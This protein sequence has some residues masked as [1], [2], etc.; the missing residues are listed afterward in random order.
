M[1][2]PVQE[3]LGEIMTTVQLFNQ[4]SLAKDLGFTTDGYCHAMCL[5]WIRRI[6]QNRGR[7]R[8]MRFDFDDADTKRRTVRRQMAIQDAL[9]KKKVDLIARIPVLQARAK[10]LDQSSIDRKSLANFIV[11][12]INENPDLDSLP[13]AA[14]F[15]PGKLRGQLEQFL[16]GV[17]AKLPAD[18]TAESLAK[19][20]KKLVEDSRPLKTESDRLKENAP[21]LTSNYAPLFKLSMPALQSTLESFRSQ[22]KAGTESTRGFGGITIQESQYK[23][24]FASKAASSVLEFVYPRLNG[25]RAAMIGFDIGKGGHEV[26]IRVESTG[27]KFLFMDPNY[28]LFLGPKD[29]LNEAFDYLFSQGTGVYNK[30]DAPDGGK[31]LGTFD[32]SIFKQ[33]G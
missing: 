7:T 29:K 3:K 22:E 18:L 4:R 28:G 1:P 9:A 13:K 33:A 8:S 32:Y 19:V 27:T 21:Q 10:S 25:E 20:A 6:L 15:P 26:A 12:T 24:K 11:D 30:P 31:V 14:I 23:Q 5:D 16:P 2:D 17:F